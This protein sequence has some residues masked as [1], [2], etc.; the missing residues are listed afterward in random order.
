MTDDELRLWGTK[1]HRVR[2]SSLEKVRR[3]ELTLREARGLADI[4]RTLAG[5]TSEQSARAIRLA[6]T[7]RRRAET[8]GQT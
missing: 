1:E 5:L 6:G 8:E 7:V 2:L 3:G 4:R